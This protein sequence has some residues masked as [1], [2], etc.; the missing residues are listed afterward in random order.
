M[1]A[2]APEVHLFHALRRTQLP[3]EMDSPQ[4]LQKRT[5]AA[6]A[7]MRAA[8]YGTAEAVPFVRRSL[9]QPLRVSEASCAGQ[10]GQLK[11]IWTSLAELSPGRSPGQRFEQRKVPQGR[12]E[13]ARTDRD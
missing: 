1:R 4:C 3:K 13:V 8:F 9:P 6:K 10:I 11:I 7:V 5:S 12:L 2:L